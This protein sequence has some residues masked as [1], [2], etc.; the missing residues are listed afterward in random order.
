MKS[1]IEGDFYKEKPEDRIS[2]KNQDEYKQGENFENSIRAY[3][4]GKRGIGLQI[5]T[6][7]PLVRRG[8][9]HNMLAHVELTYD[10]VCE[11][12]EFLDS[13]INNGK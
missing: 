7:L 8:K 13:Y 11:L 4:T 3:I 9:P 10:E 12:K 2:I 6:F 1:Y 5:R